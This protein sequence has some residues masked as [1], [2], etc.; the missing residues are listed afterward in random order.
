[1]NKGLFEQ[2]HQSMKEAVAIAKGEMQPS[3]VFT[4]EPSDINF[5]R[6]AFK[7]DMRN[8]SRAQIGE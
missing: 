1:M 7:Q 8:A 6:D 3:R 4:I 5:E 2:L